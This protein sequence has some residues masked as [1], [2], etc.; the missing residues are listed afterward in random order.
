MPTQS[1]KITIANPTNI[2]RIEYWLGGDGSGST[3]IASGWLGNPASGTWTKTFPVS[4][5][6]TYTVQLGPAGS[7]GGEKEVL[8]V[9]G[10]VVS[11]DQDPTQVALRFGYT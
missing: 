7:G 6:L 11:P 3:G 9:S 8:V 10:I 5:Y 1:G 2:E 4:G